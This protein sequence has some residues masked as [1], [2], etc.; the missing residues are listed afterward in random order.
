[1]CVCVCQEAVSALRAADGDL[2]LTV[3]L[4]YDPDEVERQIADGVLVQA[5]SASHSVSSLDRPETPPPA[6]PEPS[7][8]LPDV[9]T[10]QAGRRGHRSTAAAL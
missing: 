4:G 2:T 8:A 9:S 7:A 5:K 3:C 1:M 6:K 10:E